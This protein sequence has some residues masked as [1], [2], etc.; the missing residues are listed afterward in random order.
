VAVEYD[1]EW[2]ADGTRLRR[3]R[4]RLNRLVAE[5]WTVL[6]VTADRLRHE[7]DLLARELFACLAR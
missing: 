1:G 4:R 6:H 3:D 2:H 5:G 7:F